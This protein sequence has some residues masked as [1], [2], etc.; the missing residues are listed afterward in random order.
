MPYRLVYGADRTVTDHALR[1]STHTFQFEDGR[2][3][4]RR[5]SEAPGIANLNCDKD[6]GSMA[7]K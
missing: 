6:T 4:I 7:V 3:A 2:I 5:P 1:V